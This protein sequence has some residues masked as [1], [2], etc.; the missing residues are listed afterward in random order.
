MMPV[1]GSALRATCAPV[2]LTMLRSPVP[3]MLKA[4]GESSCSTSPRDTDTDNT[5]TPRPPGLRP[6][7]T[8][9]V[10]ADCWLLAT[11]ASAPRSMST[12][13][14]SLLTPVTPTEDSSLIPTS[15][16]LLAPAMFLSKSSLSFLY[17]KAFP[18]KCY[19]Q[20][21]YQAFPDLIPT[22]NLSFSKFLTL[23][24]PAPKILTPS[25]SYPPTCP[26][27]SSILPDFLKP[28][29]SYPTFL[30]PILTFPKLLTPPYTFSNL[31]NPILILHKLLTTLLILLILKM[32]FPAIPPNPTYP[33]QNPLT[34][35]YILTNPVPKSHSHL[36]SQIPSWFLTS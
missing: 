4:T 14:C 6:A 21:P 9:T 26:T 31:L 23:T 33:D 27:P 13:E 15:F 32:T 19:T 10:P 20:F 8:L 12:T 2:M 7:C 17:T 30:K 11:T 1:T 34:Y 5:T 29:Y 3:S 25:Y 18:D 24:F 28:K 36:S 16:P 22:P 35:H